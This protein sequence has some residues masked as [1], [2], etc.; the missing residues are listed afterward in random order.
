MVHRKQRRAR[1]VSP[2]VR[3]RKQKRLPSVISSGLDS[4]ATRLRQAV[5]SGSLKDLQFVAL[6]TAHELEELRS[7]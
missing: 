3:T 1:N 2:R 5:E 7:A 6:V 4:A